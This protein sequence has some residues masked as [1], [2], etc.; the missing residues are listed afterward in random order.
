M[1]GDINLYG[2]GY[3][4]MLAPY[5]FIRDVKKKKLHLRLRKEYFLGLPGALQSLRYQKLYCSSL[6]QPYLSP[7]QK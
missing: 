4:M 6:V 5:L 3:A 2:N 7:W 1:E